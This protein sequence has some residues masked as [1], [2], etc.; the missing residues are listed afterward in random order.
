MAFLIL[1]IRFSLKTVAD[2]TQIVTWVCFSSTYVFVHLLLNREQKKFL[3]LA[4]QK[5]ECLLFAG[6]PKA[7]TALHISRYS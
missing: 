5:G 2:L 3:F 4:I 1:R 7:K 6:T